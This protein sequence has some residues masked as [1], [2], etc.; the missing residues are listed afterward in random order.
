VLSYNKKYYDGN[1]IK[2]DYD[3]SSDF[4]NFELGVMEENLNSD[5]FDVQKNVQDVQNG[6]RGHF[7]LRPQGLNNDV[8]NA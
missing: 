5:L 7:R 3:I 4:V 2:I 6:R 8:S 1:C